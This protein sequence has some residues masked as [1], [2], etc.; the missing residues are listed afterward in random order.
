LSFSNLSYIN[1]D[2]YFKKAYVES[3]INYFPVFIELFRIF[4]HETKQEVGA[5]GQGFIPL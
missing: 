1:F 2:K 3:F 4:S 5:L